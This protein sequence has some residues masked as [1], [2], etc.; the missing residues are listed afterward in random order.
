V[1]VYPQ[2][3]KSR[4]VVND[5]DY[6]HPNSPGWQLWLGAYGD[7][8][9]KFFDHMLETMQQKFAVDD[10][11]VYAAGFSN[12]AYFCYLLWAQRRTT[13]AAMG[14]VAGALWQ[15]PPMPVVLTGPLAV[16]QIAGVADPEV[17]LP[18][19]AEAIEADQKINNAPI[20]EGD[21]CGDCSYFV[22]SKTNAKL[23]FICVRFPSASDTPVRFFVHTGGHI[24]P[25]G[26]SPE[27]VKFF[28]A[29]KRS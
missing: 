10:N 17:L 26:A 7:R 29:H 13:L 18:W 14:N 3:L 28:K 9:L 19:Q 2:G 5:T 16:M 6:D 24:Y 15:K 21:S 27:F 12:G 25:G 22:D 4:G 23:P 8:D 11:R 1:V 20:K